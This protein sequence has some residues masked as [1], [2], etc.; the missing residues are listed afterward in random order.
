VAPKNEKQKDGEEA[1]P[2]SLELAR[3]RLPDGNTSR[4]VRSTQAN[5]VGA[6]SIEPRKD[7]RTVKTDAGTLQALAGFGPGGA[8][9]GQ[10]ERA[11]GRANDT[12]Y[13]SRDRLVEAGKVIHDAEK[14]RYFAAEPKVGPGPGVVQN[15]SNSIVV[16]KVSPVVPP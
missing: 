15:G 16:Q 10:W 4:V 8:T 9:L 1:T 6:P 11:A 3:V 5:A 14:A 7:P 13:S 12:F 2:I